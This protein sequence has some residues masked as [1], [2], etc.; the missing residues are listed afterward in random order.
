MCGEIVKTI[1]ITHAIA[2][3]LF[4][5]LPLTSQL[6]AQAPGY[7]LIDMGT[8]GGPASELNS[9]DDGSFSVGVVN[10]RGSLVGWAETSQQDPFPAFCFSDDC[11]VSHAFRWQA[12]VRSDLEA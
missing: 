5:I 3:A 7:R 11:F 12:G 6:G 8:F 2:K 4:L 1:R 9:G 10:N